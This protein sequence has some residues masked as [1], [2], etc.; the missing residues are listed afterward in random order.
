MSILKN[1]RKAERL[2]Q[3]RSQVPRTTNNKEKGA[4]ADVESSPR[5]DPFFLGVH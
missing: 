1:A 5:T 2:L 3:K 4:F